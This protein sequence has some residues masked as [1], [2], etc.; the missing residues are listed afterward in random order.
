[1]CKALDLIVDTGSFTCFKHLFVG[2]CDPA[3]SYIVHDGVVKQNWILWYYTNS[4][5]KAIFDQHQK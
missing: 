5:T 1:M 3:I 4:I 2:C